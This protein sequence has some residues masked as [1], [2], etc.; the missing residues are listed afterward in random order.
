MRQQDGEYEAVES[1]RVVRIAQRMY[2]LT[3]AE[4]HTF[5]VGE[6]QWLVHN[7]NCSWPPDLSGV[8]DKLEEVAKKFPPTSG[9]CHKC[10]DAMADFIRSLG[11][12][13]DIAHF[14]SP[15]RTGWMGTLDNRTIGTNGWHEMVRI[16]GPNEDLLIDAEILL[17]RGPHPVRQQ[18]LTQYYQDADLWSVSFY[19]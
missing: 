16:K 1:L 9:Q 8:K 2:N 10:A 4:A 12:E 5:F 6:A 18:D 17:K 3:V 11:Y 14:V 15:S 7:T 19:R 13:V